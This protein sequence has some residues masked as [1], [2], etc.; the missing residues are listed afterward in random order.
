MDSKTAQGISTADSKYNTFMYKIKQDMS[1]NSSEILLRIKKLRSERERIVRKRRT[2]RQKVI[3]VTKDYKM[4]E[5]ELDDIET[6][7][8]GDQRLY[9]SVLIEEAKADE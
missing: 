2:L 3:K 8:R 6:K 5:H 1:P 4:I 7:I 9:E